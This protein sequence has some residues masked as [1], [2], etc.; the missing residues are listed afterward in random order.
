MQVFV[1]IKSVGMMINIDA[2]LKNW[3]I[4][5]YVIDDIFRILVIL[6]VNVINHVVLESIWIKRIVNAGKD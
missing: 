5:V 2:N 4:R 1:T 6:C 3:L